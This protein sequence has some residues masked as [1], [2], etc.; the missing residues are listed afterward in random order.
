MAPRTTIEQRELVLK[1]FKDGKTQRAIAE[2]VCLSPSTVQC[3]IQRFVRENRVADKG[4][5]APNKIFDDHEERRI[6]RK[7]KENPKLSA[8]KIAA[9]VEE[10][11]GKKCCPDTIRNVLH[12][13]HLNGRVARKK[14]FISKKNMIERVK[15]VKEMEVHPGTFW[16]DV[17]FADESK[18]NLFG[19]DGRK[20][21]WRRA[22]T[23]LDPKNLKPT[24][25]HGG[26]H[27]MVW[28]CMAASGVGN[29]VF[30]D[31]I[32]DAKMYL[33]I[34][35][36]NLPQSAEKLGI[37]DRF[38]FYQDN[39]PK[40]TAANVKLWLVW[41]CPHVVKTPAQSPDLNVIE[42]LWEILD[43]AIRK[44]TISN[45]NELKIALLEEWRKIPVETTK[46]LVES[47]GNRLKAVKKQKGGPTKY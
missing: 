5:I 3:I 13:H 22:N 12:K 8:P 18:F 23:E 24:V 20:Y 26:G 28:A 36:E 16:N 31:G 37:L 35:K 30:I 15:F 25:K 41:N 40:H 29:L 27:V 6:V 34:L 45:R 2:I 46:K 21:V 19:S 11:M 1:H 33:N 17:I 7:V 9:E 42:N 39:D 14:P 44:R 43:Q 32:M 38:R 10:E 47:M 4:R